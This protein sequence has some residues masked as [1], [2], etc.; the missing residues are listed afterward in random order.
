MISM[1]ITKQWFTIACNDLFVA[2]YTY[3]NM[4]PKC[5]SVS[6]FHCQQAAEKALKG[7]L[8]YKG[9]DPSRIDID[10]LGVLCRECM[11]LDTSF[12]TVLEA[13]SNLSPY[14]IEASDLLVRGYPGGI[15]VDEKMTQTAIAQAQ[16]VYDFAL[17]KVPQ[18]V[19]AATMDEE[20]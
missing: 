6:C 12:S 20:E 11:E 3:E 10:D 19:S 14:G 1:S 18:K 16:A 15:V 5:P 17:S 7:Y 9:K 2:K 13:A 4:S 8:Q